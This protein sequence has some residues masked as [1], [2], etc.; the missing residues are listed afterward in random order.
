MRRVAVLGALMLS[1]AGAIDTAAT[2]A[3]GEA[4]ARRCDR[5]DVFRYDV[6]VTGAKSGRE[7]WPP[8]SDFTGEFLLSYDYVV[9]YLRVRVVVDH[10]CDPE[11]TTVRARGRGTGTLQNY[12]WA[13]RVVP[14]DPSSTRVPCE[15]GFTT[16]P[17]RARLRVVG[18]TKV[19]GGGPSTFSTGSQL[20]R[21]PQNAVLD[22]IEARRSEAC[23]NGGSQNFRAS[24]ELATHRSVPIFENPAR[25]GNVKVEPP[26]I[27]LDGSLLGGGR[28]NPRALARL[29]AGRSV[30]VS[31]GLRRYEGTDDQSIATATAAVTV[32]FD[33]RR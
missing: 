17:L 21:A 1:L 28:R 19:L 11:I 27:F 4:A 30:R 2:T 22:L 9:R 3:T 31:T 33:R 10:G 20:N 13:D 23:A 24:D 16:G 7:T 26:S 25:V 32:R 8:E 15:F 18:G 6:T 5:V 12:T 14:K 29:V